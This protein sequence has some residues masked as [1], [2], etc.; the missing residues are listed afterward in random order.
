MKKTKVLAAGV[1]TLFFCACNDSKFEG[2][3]RAE[4]GLHYRFFNHDESGVKVQEGDGIL[5]RYLIMNQ[6]N[7]SV[8]VDSKNVSRDGSGYTGFGMEGSTFRGSLEDGMMMMA[9]GD[10]AEFIV[11]ADSFFLKSMKYNELPQGI[12][13]G[14]NL[15]ALIKI[16]EITPKAELEAD[17]SKRM[18]EKEKQMQESKGLEQPALEKYLAEN[19]VKT[20]PT[21]SGIYYI[22]TKKGTGPQ[23]KATDVVKVHYTGRLLDGT[24]FDSSEGGE[25]AQFGLNQVIPGWTE[26]LQMMKKGGKA[27]LILPSSMAYGAQGTPGGPIPPYS[28]LVFDVE[29]IDIVPA[30]T[31]AR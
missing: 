26:G 23:P 8:I 17:R 10:S 20:K 5:I 11:P 4:N 25:P 22:E 15:R 30:G 9:A 13:S 12:Q 19:K 6:R 16:K 2:F 14:D 7:D 27:Q 29:L 18:A 1:M 3:T 31:E 28:P 21:E 24:V